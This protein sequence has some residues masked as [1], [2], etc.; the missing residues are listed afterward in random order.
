MPKKASSSRICERCHQE[1]EIELFRLKNK[2]F[3]KI[4]LDCR[5]RCVVCGNLI[6]NQTSLAIKYCSKACRRNVDNAQRAEK[7]SK[8]VFYNPDYYK[9]QYQIAKAK[10]WKIYNPQKK[11]EY[12]LTVVKP[13]YQLDR[14]FRLKTIEAVKAYYQRNRDVILD[15]KRNMTD[16]QREVYNSRI[17]KWRKNRW[18]NMNEEQRLALK[19]YQNSLNRKSRMRLRLAMMRI[20]FAKIENLKVEHDE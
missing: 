10:G 12:Y 4:C 5:K 13:K 1:K 16:E 9:E 19:R 18:E 15:K 8:V 20:N 6:A 7:L 3:G 11:Q 17:R 2:K 14:K